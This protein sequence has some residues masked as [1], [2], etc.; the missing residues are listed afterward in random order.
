MAGL[1]QPDFE[2]TFEDGDG[3]ARSERSRRR[4]RRRKV[5]MRKG[6]WRDLAEKLF[7]GFR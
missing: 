1:K 4:R 6:F 2:I 5:E 7:A 3:G